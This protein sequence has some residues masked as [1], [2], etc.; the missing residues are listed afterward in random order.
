MQASILTPR[1]VIMA[2]PVRGIDLDHQAPKVGQFVVA[3]F[4]QVQRG[5]GITA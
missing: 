2:D 5:I 1:R 4:G 3:E